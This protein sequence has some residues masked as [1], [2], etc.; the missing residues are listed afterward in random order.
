M[1][2]GFDSFF[3]A[4]FECSSHRRKDGV[5][6]DLIRA[7]GHDK[8]VLQDYR[9]CRDLGFRTIRDGLRWHLIE[10]APDQYDWSSWLPMLEAA[11]EA[12][13][14]VIWDL[15][16]YGSPDCVD[17]GAPDFPERFTNFAIAALELQQSVSGRPPLVCPLNEINFLSWAVDDGYFPHVGPDEIGWIKN[18]LVRTAITA[19]RA[20]KQ[21]WPAATIVWAEPLIHIAPHD[22]RRETIRGAQ[23][24]LQGM[25]EAYDWIMGLA[26]PELGGDRSLVDVIGW[27]FYPHNQWYWKGPTIPMGHHEYR[28]LADMLVEMGERY[29]KPMFLSETGAEG[30]AKPS[31][32]HY[33]CNEVREAMSRGADIRG[34]C[35]YPITAY[36]G[37]DNS[38][39]A[40]TGLLSPVVAD[41]TRHVNSRLLEEFEVQ[42]EMFD[43]PRKPQAVAS[44]AR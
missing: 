42:R 15:F 24:I 3:M 7:T 37:W 44:A 33:V 8:H 17:Q 6:L 34:L 28:P 38:R 16:H 21:Q 41:G 43:P 30:T 35:W 26:R 29:Q 2:N 36:P 10:K 1:K 31:W 14:Q 9:Q 39:H 40:D 18:Q 12:G 4:G 27:N 20:I 32:L 23:Q 25:Y 19:A 22:L 11:E 13:V 5:R